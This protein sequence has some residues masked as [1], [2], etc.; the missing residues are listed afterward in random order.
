MNLLLRKLRL[1][2]T[3]SQLVVKLPLTLFMQ[4]QTCTKIMRN[5]CIFN[6]TQIFSFP[7]E[8]VETMSPNPA[9]PRS[10]WDFIEKAVIPKCN[11][12]KSNMDHYCF[13]PPSRRLSCKP[14]TGFWF[15]LRFVVMSHA[16]MLCRENW[17]CWQPQLW[18][19]KA[20]GS[21]C[22]KQENMPHTSHHAFLTG[23]HSP[24]FSWQLHWKITS[25]EIKSL[26][27]RAPREDL[28]FNIY[29]HNSAVNIPH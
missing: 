1:L 11:A 23:E 3:W 5:P 9:H 6:N 21:A 4:E 20:L 15:T 19:A 14:W 7:G 8:S 22:Q 25:P 16:G 10:W 29:S 24:W 26:F 2:K 27:S 28:G 12:S 18:A 13:F 17:K